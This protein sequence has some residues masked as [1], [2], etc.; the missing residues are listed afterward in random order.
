MNEC[1]SELDPERI[2]RLLG[3]G[4]LLAQAMEKGLEGLRERGARPWPEPETPEALGKL[5]DE[6]ADEGY[7]APRQQTLSAKRHGCG[8]RP[9]NG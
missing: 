7:G 1:R 3:R 9:G 6:A 8:G 2:E 4:L 5:L